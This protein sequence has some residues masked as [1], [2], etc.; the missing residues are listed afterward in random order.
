MEAEAMLAR[1]LE[2][3]DG[4]LGTVASTF[5]QGVG[6]GELRTLAVVQAAYHAAR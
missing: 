4:T 3:A 5:S 2:F 6:S 1:A